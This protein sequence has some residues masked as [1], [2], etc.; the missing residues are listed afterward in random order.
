M[1]DTHNARVGQ[2]LFKDV[3]IG[4]VTLPG[5]LP[6]RREVWL[7]SECYEEELGCTAAE[8]EGVSG[9]QTT[10]RE[11]QGSGGVWLFPPDRTLADGSPGDRMLPR[12]GGG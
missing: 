4:M 2:T 7:N 8:Q 1:H 3:L 11:G 12:D 10:G 9:W 5:L 6:C